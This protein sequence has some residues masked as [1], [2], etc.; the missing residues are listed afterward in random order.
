MIT[1]AE[2]SFR[3]VCPLLLV[4]VMS[5]ISAAIVP[6][7]ALKY[8][9]AVQ[10]AA[11]ARRAAPTLRHIEI[12]ATA[13]RRFNVPASFTRLALSDWCTIRPRSSTIARCVSDRASRACCSTTMTDIPLSTIA[14][15]L[16]RAP[17]LRQAFGPQCRRAH[18]D[19]PSAA[20]RRVNRAWI[21]SSPPNMPPRANSTITIRSMPSQ[22]CQ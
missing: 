6:C 22:N 15:G 14:V 16:E 4:A 9:M 5:G 19:L 21:F 1:G 18:A 3:S 11:S 17:L 13:T 12:L 20:P 10:L 7:T 8:C 2:K